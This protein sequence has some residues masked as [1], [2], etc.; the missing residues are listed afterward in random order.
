MA[1]GG[2]TIGGGT[3]SAPAPVPRRITS[4]CAAAVVATAVVLSALCLYGL[5]CFWPTS[6]DPRPPSEQVAF[7]GVDLDLRAE[8]LMFVVVALA[9]ALGGLIHV[10]RSVSEYIGNRRLVRSWLPYYTLLPLVGA[11][12][13]TVLYVVLRGGL[14]SGA[15]TTAEVNSYGFAAL[16]A[17]AGLFSRQATEKLRK[18]FD[19]IFTEVEPQE[20][21]LE[22]RADDA[23]AREGPAS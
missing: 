2:G 6:A 10:L 22:T 9:G 8:V 11:A 14:F 1:H 15:S 23:A 4:A 19:V 13:A 3:T 17:L 21:R 18:V 20:D 12:L 7:L 16:A 5:W